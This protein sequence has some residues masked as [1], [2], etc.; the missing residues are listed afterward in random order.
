ML[1]NLKRIM[2]LLVVSILAFS[3]GKNVYA[4]ASP[5]DCSSGNPIVTTDNGSTCYDDLSEAVEALKTSG[6]TIKVLQSFTLPSP[7]DITMSDQTKQLTLDLQTYTITGTGARTLNIEKGDVTITGTGKIVNNNTGS[8]DGTIYIYGEESTPGTTGYTK[9]KIDTGVT[10]EGINPVV[11]STHTYANYGTEL[12]IDGKLLNTK[13]GTADSAALTIH[14][15]IKNASGT[16]N[17]P[18]I[19]INGTLESKYDDAPGGGAGIYQAGYAIT[20][21]SNGSVK[22]DTGIV[23]KSGELTLNTATVTAT[24]V[25]ADG[26]PLGN[27]YI[28][29]GAAIQIESNTSYAGQ[30][31]LTIQDSTLHSDDNSAIL[32]YNNGAS[33]VENFTLD[34]VTFE[35]PEDKDAMTISSESSST[36]TPEEHQVTIETP[37]NGTLTLKYKDDASNI[38]TGSNV[39]FGDLVEIEAIPKD[40]YHLAKIS[41]TGNPTVKNNSFRMPNNAIT[42]SASF[43]RNSSGSS[44]SDRSVTIEIKDEKIDNYK[45]G[46]TT[47]LQDI[48]DD[49]KTKYSNIIGFTDGYNNKLDLDTVTYDGMYLIAILE[50][51]TVSESPKTFDAIMTTIGLGLGSLAVISLGTKKYLRKN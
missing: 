46:T 40:G 21:I 35:V 48:L 20:T 16:S 24:G 17:S 39:L 11:I 33:K 41:I 8:N 50:D 9:V 31:K 42:V 32:E 14:G 7:V 27:G 18:K 38:P 25:G 10:I 45:I 34:D 44:S 26:Q 28:G 13:K 19:T 36:V 1:T 30:I 47:T 37:S 3:F 23:I 49:L 5:V 15:D 51:E 29:T 22:G 4:T 6:G 2:G 12:T 43:V